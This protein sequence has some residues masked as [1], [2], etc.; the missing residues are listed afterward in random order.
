MS[1]WS[2]YAGEEW[3]DTLF[4]P[5]AIGGI[6]TYFERVSEISRACRGSVDR[7]Y[8][9][10]DQIDRR[11]ADRLKQSTEALRT[12]RQKIAQKASELSG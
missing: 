11:N 8:E 5:N 6:N 4:I 10:A 2:Q 3:Y 1:G 7:I 12:L 9:Q